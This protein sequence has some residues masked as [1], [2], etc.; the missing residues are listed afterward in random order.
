MAFDHTP[1]SH[2]GQESEQ[3]LVQYGQEC[4]P[5]VGMGRLAQEALLVILG[6]LRGLLKCLAR[7]GHGTETKKQDI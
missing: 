7:P 4:G 2:S 1:A 6:R 3:I 5:S